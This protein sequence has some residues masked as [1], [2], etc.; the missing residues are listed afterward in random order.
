MRIAPHYGPPTLH[1]PDASR[2][3]EVVR[4]LGEALAVRKMQTDA[5]LRHLADGNVKARRTLVACGLVDR[6]AGRRA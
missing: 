4:K 6:R 5:K 1:V 3:A 2:A